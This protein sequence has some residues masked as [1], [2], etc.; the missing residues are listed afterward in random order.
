VTIGSPRFPAGDEKKGR[1][2]GSYPGVL[3]AIWGS[4]SSLSI[5]CEIE[6]VDSTH[7]KRRLRPHSG[8]GRSRACVGMG[9]DAPAHSRRSQGCERALAQNPPPR[10]SEVARS[11]GSEASLASEP[12]ACPGGRVARVARIDS[13]APFLRAGHRRRRSITLG[14]RRGRMPRAPLRRPWPRS[15][16]GS[17]Q[18]KNGPNPARRKLQADQTIRRPIR[19]PQTPLPVPRRPS[20]ARGPPGRPGVSGPLRPIEHRTP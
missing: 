9:R 15:R 19:H 11:S 12:W 1:S 2:R 18:A 14:T 17:R 4:E 10:G 3:G 8:R 16:P 7:P 20:P 6:C 5:R 13:V